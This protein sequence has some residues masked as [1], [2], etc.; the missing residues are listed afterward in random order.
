MPEP[1]HSRIFRPIGPYTASFRRERS[2]QKSARGF[3]LSSVAK[4]KCALDSVSA[5]LMSVEGV[6]LI[7]NLAVGM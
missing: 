4:G 2:S 6:V 5:V 3:R 1:S 7:Q